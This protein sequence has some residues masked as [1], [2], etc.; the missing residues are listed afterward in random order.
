[1]FSGIIQS[2]APVT[3]ITQDQGGVRISLDLSG[4]LSAE[5]VLGESIS[6]NGAC[7]TLESLTGEI[8]T[9]YSSPE[10]LRLTNLASLQPGSL[11]NLELCL[12]PSTRMGGHIVSGH[13]DC[14][15]E[16]IMTES[17]GESYLMHYQLPAEAMR[18]VIY[19]G[20]IALN[21]ISLTIAEIDEQEHQIKVAIIPH[22][23]SETNLHTLRSGDQ[24]NCELDQI[25]KY[26]EKL[27]KT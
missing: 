19:K 2:L 7:H 25:A 17:E 3:E 15:A 13:I 14:L 16:L 6:L 20:S 9:F 4:L 21:G 12:T 10:T 26:I 27:F 23:W 18:Y 8:G 11:V 24:V 5:L 1:M 22:T